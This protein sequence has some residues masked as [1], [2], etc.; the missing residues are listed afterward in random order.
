MKLFKSIFHFEIT[1][2]VNLFLYYFKKIPLIGKIF[3]DKIYQELSLKKMLSYVAFI[4][5]SLTNLVLSVLSVGLAFFLPSVLFYKNQSAGSSFSAF[6]Y[7][8]FVLSI[9]SE[10]FLFSEIFEPTRN[11]VIAIRLMHFPLKEYLLTQFYYKLI[12][13]FICSLPVYI[14][15]TLLLKGTFLQALLFPF[16][17]TCSKLVGEALQILLFQKLKKNIRLQTPLYFGLAVL[18]LVA[19]YVPVVFH[20]PV[21]KANFIFSIPFIIFIVILGM[22]SIRFIQSYTHYSTIFLTLSTSKKL[23]VDSKKAAREASFADVKLKDTDYTVSLQHQDKFNHKSGYAYLNA[24]FFERHRRMILKPM[25]IS[26]LLIAIIFFAAV[27]ANQFVSAIAEHYMNGIIK[28]FPSF[29]FIMYLLSIQLCQRTTKA[30]FYNCDISLLRYAYYRKKSVILSNFRIR[31]KKV[32]IINGLPSLAITLS[33]FLFG[34]IIDSGRIAEIVP[35]L[36]LIPLLSVFFS[37]HHLFMYYVLQPYTT[38][39]NVKNPLYRIIDGIM[40][41][42]CYLCL[43]IHEAPKNFVLLVFVITIIYTITA[44]ILILKYA[45]KNFKVK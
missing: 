16:L 3:S 40:Y 9:L 39:L 4:I 6:V 10:V 30:M 21:F 32:I 34:L 35:I 23:T 37:V 17:I 12:S 1:M 36:V 43:Q 42:V 22:L 14:L 33:L 24:I 29:I 26:L 45:P 41:F 5:K 28:G 18:F 2:K 11:K 19:A 13:G 15:F 20:L 27:I 44:L 25:Y 7:L 31:L 38:E 8:F